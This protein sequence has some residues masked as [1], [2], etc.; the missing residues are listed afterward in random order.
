MKLKIKILGANCSK[1]YKVYNRFKSLIEDYGINASV[2]YS[3]DASEFAKHSILALPSVIINDEIVFKGIVP[4][5]NQIIQTLNNY[6]DENK[7]IEQLTELHYTKYI[8]G[9][10]TLIL[11]LVTVTMLFSQIESNT[12]DCEIIKTNSTINYN[13]GSSTLD[14]NNFQYNYSIS[15]SYEMTFLEFGAIGCRACKM[16]ESVLEE[17]R[18]KY[19]GKVNV[20]FYN[21]RTDD[22]KLYADYFNVHAIPVQ[23]LL[24]KEGIEIF[25]H[26]GYFSSEQLS[27]QFLKY[28][29]KN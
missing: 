22:G 17:I 18:S 21:V 19:R 6:L 29:I 7:K 15:N 28:G 5:K 20:I 12:Q 26:T 24:N 10:L 27:N 13:L 2:N 11:I 4:S 14:S 25:R 1:C 3:S 23:V 16:M 9:F 8:I